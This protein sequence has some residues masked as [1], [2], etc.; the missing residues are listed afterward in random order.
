M[1]ANKYLKVLIFT[2]LKPET[3]LDIVLFVVL[4]TSGCFPAS[5]GQRAG[6][7]ATAYL[8]GFCLV[9][10]IACMMWAVM[11]V[12]TTL[13]WSMQVQARCNMGDAKWKVKIFNDKDGDLYLSFRD[14]RW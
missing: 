3:D 8:L 12:V 14:L 13:T 9:S 2:Y 4:F 6:I 10:Q 7:T 1:R 11:V 5:R